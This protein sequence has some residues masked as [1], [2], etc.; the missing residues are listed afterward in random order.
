MNAAPETLL[1]SA[2]RTALPPKWQQAV[3]Q[4]L[5]DTGLAHDH[6]RMVG[7]G[8]L[9]R[10]PKQSQMQL[11]ASDNLAYQSACFTRAAPSG[12]TP[13]LHSVLPVSTAL[14]RGALL[15]QEIVGCKAQ[16][17]RDLPAIAQTLASLHRL[18]PPLNAA[19]LW[20]AAD[21]LSALRTE[22]EAQW[23]ISV[24]KNDHEKSH[25]SLSLYTN[26]AIKREAIT[27]E[28]LCKLPLRP[29]RS[30]ISFD[31][32][33]GNYVVQADGEAILVD[34]EKCRYSYPGLD[35]AHATLYT[36]TTWDINSCAVLTLPEVLATYQAW[37]TAVGADTAQAALPWHVPLR[38]AMWLW[39]ITWCA[40]WQA[41]SGLRAKADAD[42][43]DW[44]AQ[45][46]D[47][48]LIAHVRERVAHY[49][50]PDVVSTVLQGFDDLHQALG[51]PELPA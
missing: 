5:P 9:A 14:P 16:L 6:V 24:E 28:K 42:G 44:S 22:I 37:G 12:H 26:S 32:H 4:R 2:L 27:L 45:H 30:L 19:P 15:V 50:A 34:L 41:L 10:I 11:A 33:P 20:S 25:Y 51:A 47:D 43:E 3:L 23:G 48:A 13:A 46:S 7:T 29:P 18:P 49:L 40:K 35:L 38:R 21:P 1:L 31:G 8:L 36:S 39:S 17:P